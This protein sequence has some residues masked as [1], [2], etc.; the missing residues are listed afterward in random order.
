M[1][2]LLGFV[3]FALVVGGISGLLSDHL[4]GLHVFGFVKYLV[5]DGHRT[6]GYLVLIV[7]GVALA[8]GTDRIGR[9]PQG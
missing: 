3:S 1:K 8:V 9:R 2:N 6:A 5:P 4:W 7:L